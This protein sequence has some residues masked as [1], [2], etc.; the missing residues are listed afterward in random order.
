MGADDG[1][2]LASVPDSQRPLLP[3][4]AVAASALLAVAAEQVRRVAAARRLGARAPAAY[5]RAVAAPSCRVLLVGDSTGAGV[6]CE[7]PGESIAARLARDVPGAEVRNLCASGAT[8]AQVLAVVQALPHDARWDLVLVFAGGNDVLRHT[9]APALD[10]D[11]RAL[12]RALRPRAAQV[13]WAGMANVGLAPLFLPP[14]SWWMS[15]R[16]RRVNRLLR[17]VARAEGAQYAEFY[18]ERDRC[19][20]SAD[21]DRYFARDGVHPSAQAYARCYAVLRPAIA[22]ALALPA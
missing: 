22:R 10:R 21:P 11:A 13:L 9:A 15:A 6:G 2:M 17:Q 20:F 8:V 1:A 5:G 4:L 19:P 18:A 3:A 16:T 12:L 7:H 14:F